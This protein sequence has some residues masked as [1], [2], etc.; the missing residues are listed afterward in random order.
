M[1]DAVHDSDE[2]P[3]FATVN[4]VWV[5]A[6]HVLRV[7]A[8]GETDRIG[9][10]RAGVQVAVG[11]AR[12]VVVGTGV[13]ID[14][15]GAVVDSGP[16]DGPF[17]RDAPPVPV[18]DA[19]PGV[20]PPEE[21]DDACDEAKAVDVVRG[22]RTIWTVLRGARAP[23]AAPVTRRTSADSRT[24]VHIAGRRCACLRC[25]CPWR[26]GLAPT[27]TLGS[28]HRGTCVARDLPGGVSAAAAPSAPAVS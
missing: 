9:G 11:T 22:T 19:P 24:I 8:V 12:G 13:P 6:R 15:C 21:R 20:L 16:A 25:V 26:S 28:G 17:T 27:R 4:W 23:I 5:I 10:A 7:I 18:P 3:V 2:P 14:D 1:A